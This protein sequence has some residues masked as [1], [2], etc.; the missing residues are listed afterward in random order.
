VVRV[1]AVVV[2]MLYESDA[3]SLPTSHEKS[4]LAERW[5]L[6][7]LGDNAVQRRP[8]SFIREELEISHHLPG[9]V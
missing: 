2:Q 3:R 6:L 7:I 8:A 9:D 1:G 4:R 5:I